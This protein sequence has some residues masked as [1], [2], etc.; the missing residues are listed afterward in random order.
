M[1]SLFLGEETVRKGVSNY[2]NKHKFSNAEQDDLWESLTEEAHKNKVLPQNLNVKTIMDTWTLQTGYP[3]IT[4]KRNYEQKSVE[5]T[6]VRISQIAT[7]RNSIN[8]NYN[9]QLLVFTQFNIVS[10]TNIFNYS[11]QDI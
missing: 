9:I 5:I 6:Q 2:L 1:M 11:R 8:N 3:V 7:E 4:V 10:L